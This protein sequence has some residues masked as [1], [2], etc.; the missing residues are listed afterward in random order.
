MILNSDTRNVPNRF[1][2]N[3]Y[4]LK[5]EDLQSILKLLS[6]KID[7][8]DLESSETAEEEDEEKTIEMS[9]S[10]Y[11]SEEEYADAYVRYKHHLDQFK[12]KSVTLYSLSSSEKGHDDYLIRKQ[13]YNER[14]TSSLESSWK[15]PP[16]SGLIPAD[17]PQIKSAKK[18]TKNTTNS[19]M[20]RSLMSR[21]SSTNIINDSGFDPDSNGFDPDSNGFFNK[22]NNNMT[23]ERRNMGSNSFSFS[24]DVDKDSSNFISLDNGHNCSKLISSVIEKKSKINHV[25]HVENYKEVDR[26]QMIKELPKNAEIRLDIYHDINSI[27]PEMTELIY[28]NS[29]TNK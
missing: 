3:L 5:D 7:I 10:L 4:H 29:L 17:Q 18:T 8:K 23:W 14:K 24:C 6:K 13:F 22:E 1:L 25:L 21:S 11:S 15:S 19:L 20:S 26:V 2:H 28:S 9:S 16:W 12:N 27:E